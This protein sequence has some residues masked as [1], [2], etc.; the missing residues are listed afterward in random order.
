MMG[1]KRMHL[2]NCKL[3]RR[4]GNLLGEVPIV[5]LYR[6]SVKRK[7]WEVTRGIYL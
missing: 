2:A 5:G 1:N 3:T 7:I 6:I 4:Y